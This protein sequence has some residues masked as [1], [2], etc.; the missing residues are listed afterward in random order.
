MTLESMYDLGQQPRIT[1]TF[2]SIS[3]GL[4]VDP[5]DITATVKKPD[6]TV[7]TYDYN[8]GAIIRDSLGVYHLDLTTDQPGTWAARIVGTGAAA[9]VGTVTFYV[10][11]DPTATSVNYL[12]RDD[13]KNTVS[14]GGSYADPDIDRALAAASRAVDDACNR[15]FYP[16]ANANSVRYYTP[17]AFDRI[18][19]DDL[20]T[21]TSLKTSQFGDGTFTTTWTLNN[22]IVLEPLNA[23]ADG[24]PYTRIK[25][26]PW[27]ALLGFPHW[28]PRSVELTGKFGWAAPPAPIVQATG[29]V[30]KR[31]LERSKSAVG[32][33]ITTEMATR[34]SSSDPDVRTLLSTYI[35]EQ[36]IL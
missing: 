1:E 4:P 16:D 15:R 14:L 19:I 2:T 9:D 22:T 18:L 21:F 35:R 30:A 36:I 12:S 31:L 8:P 27:R 23:S 13:L 17:Q 10:R 32:I 11:S 5:T 34:I 3:T 24:W 28:A 26:N 7:T 20:L 25:L 33:V 6:G 29:L